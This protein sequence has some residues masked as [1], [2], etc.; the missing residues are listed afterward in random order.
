VLALLLCLALLAPTLAGCGEGEIVNQPPVTT[1]ESAGLTGGSSGGGSNGG[2]DGGGSAPSGTISGRVG[3]GTQTD[4]KAVQANVDVLDAT[5]KT[6]ASGATDA[7]GDYSV[8]V[9]GS[10]PALLTVR[11]RPTALATYRAISK[12]LDFLGSARVDLFPSPTLLTGTTVDS[13]GT[14]RSV[15]IW[16]F[17]EQTPGQGDFMPYDIAGGRDFLPPAV[18]MNAKFGFD[19]GPDGTFEIPIRVP[20]GNFRLVF[21]VDRKTEMVA[22]TVVESFVTGN[23]NNVAPLGSLPAKAFASTSF[24]N[25]V[26]PILTASCALSGCHSVAS[27]SAGMNLAAGQ[28][29]KSLVNVASGEAPTMKRIQPSDGYMSYVYQK[30]ALTSPPAGAQMPLVGSKLDNARLQT[31]LNWIEEGA[32]DN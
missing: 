26:Q 24:A 30:V 11:A 5:G 7:N 1:T 9:P 17:R 28:S 21:A 27:P 3:D 6:L 20:D 4:F 8:K 10:S 25:D 2:G 19:T 12:K 22:T 16:V 15:D 32:R 31:V 18:M 13:N 14:P 29:F 23:A